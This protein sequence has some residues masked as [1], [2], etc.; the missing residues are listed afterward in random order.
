[1]LVLQTIEFTTER[2]YL[3]PSL[4]VNALGKYPL[5]PVVPVESQFHCGEIS[6]NKS[7]L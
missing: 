2:K 7:Q 3:P 1:M 6:L 4:S 5:G